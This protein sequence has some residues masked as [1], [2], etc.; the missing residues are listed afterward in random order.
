MRH[1]P[2]TEATPT[3]VALAVLALAGCG[4]GAGPGAGGPAGQG[5]PGAG[6]PPPVAVTLISAERGPLDIAVAM[7]GTVRAVDQVVLTSRAAGQV[8]AIHFTDGARVAAGTL[9]VELDADAERAAVQEAQTRRDDAEREATLATK[10]IEQGVGTADRVDALKARLAQAEAALAAAK[11]RLDDLAIRAPFAGRLGLRQVSV[12]TLVAP[13]TAV[14]TLATTDP[15]RV[16]FGVP[17]RYVARVRTGMTI[18]AASAAHPGR[19]FTGTVQ[20]FEAAIDPGTR[21]LAALA[22][23]PNGDE[24][25][26]IGQSLDVHLLI[27]RLPEAVTVPEEAV[28]L[29]GRQAQ[30]WLA[31]EG[32]AVL[33]PITIGQRRSGRV[34]VLDG[35]QGGEQVVTRG[36]QWLRDGAPVNAAEATAADKPA[37]EAKPADAP[38]ADAKPVDASAPPAH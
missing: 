4:G 37:A 16:Q 3:L 1:F 7:V 11:A 15:V 30:V 2:L 13:G 9:L 22:E 26:T 18:E 35:L 38:A 33:R 21:T 8:K 20:A 6:G 31:V 12:G 19:T 36:V 27:E 29:S 10:L 32:K 5:G 34:Q 23:L 24:A 17:E 14:A 28:V 25:L